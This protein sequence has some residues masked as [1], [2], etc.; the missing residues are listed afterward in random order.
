[1]DVATQAHLVLQAA[2]LIL[3]GWLGSAHRDSTMLGIHPVSGKVW[4][5]GRP[6]VALAALQ[7]MQL[8]KQVGLEHSPLCL[9]IPG[10]M[11]LTHNMCRALVLRSVRR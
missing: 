9:H 1:M 4:T 10:G 7:A 11:F 3:R 6:A 5:F 2:G 8:Y